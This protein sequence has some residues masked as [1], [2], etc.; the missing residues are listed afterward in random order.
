MNPKFKLN[1]LSKFFK[2][3]R[4]LRKIIQMSKVKKKNQKSLKVYHLP[5]NFIKQ[6]HDNLLFNRLEKTIMFL[7]LGCVPFNYS[8]ISFQTWAILESAL[9]FGFLFYAY[10]ESH[11]CHLAKEIVISNKW[12]TIQIKIP[13]FSFF[14]DRINYEILDLENKNIIQ[15]KNSQKFYDKDKFR[16]KSPHKKSPFVKIKVA[17]NSTNSNKHIFLDLNQNELKQRNNLIIEQIK[18]YENTKVDDNSNNP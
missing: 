13:K 18:E 15:M 11:I 3:S 12:E 7:S 2:Q 5:D 14:S 4:N 10:A 6:K 8:S 17:L 9:F 1:L 16:T